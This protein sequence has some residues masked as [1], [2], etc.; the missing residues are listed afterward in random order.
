V[1][2]LSIIV[3]C[4]NDCYE[5]DN[6]GRFIQ[7]L[8]FN[9]KVLDGIRVDYEYLVGEWNPFNTCLSDFDRTKHLFEDKRFKDIIIDE[10]VVEAEGLPPKIFI[11]YH[12]KNGLARKATKDNLLF[13]NSDILLSN[14]LMFTIS[15]LLKKGLE[16]RFYRTRYRVNI[17]SDGSV[18]ERSDLYDLNLP[19]GHLCAGFSGDFLLLKKSLF[20]LA[21]G[22]DEIN[23]GHRIGRQTFMDGELLYQLDKLGIK[24]EL[25][26]DQ[27]F[28]L[29]H[30]KTM[31]YQSAGYNTNGYE[32]K[33][34][35]GFVKYPTK[36]LGKAL[37]IYN[38]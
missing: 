23:P 1:E 32:N 14:D 19:D 10:S 12:M 24:L 5:G 37:V 25:L 8:E 30:G 34:D 15:V 6:I 27:Y 20:E 18:I 26:S 35:W 7:S 38:T 17:N 9:K 16:D 31:G 22:Y 11:E 36:K 33:E 13:I 3:G 28:H 2:S 29:S 21:K 4:R